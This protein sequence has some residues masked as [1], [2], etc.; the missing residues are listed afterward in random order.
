MDLV[1]LVALWRRRG[2]S[3][4][5]EVVGYRGGRRKE[6]TREQRNGGDKGKWEGKGGYKR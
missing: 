5:H 2:G 4:L 3:W 1:T 6:E